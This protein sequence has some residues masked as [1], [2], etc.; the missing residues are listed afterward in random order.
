MENDN[1]NT[2]DSFIAE[3]TRAQELTTSL[4]SFESRKNEAYADAAL[5]SQDLSFPKL[6]TDGSLPD[7]TARPS[8]QQRSLSTDMVR[9]Y[10]E[11]ESSFADSDYDMIASDDEATTASI[12][13]GGQRTPEYSG[14]DA[15]NEEEEHQQ[16]ELPQNDQAKI[17][18]VSG[19]FVDLGEYDTPTARNNVPYDAENMDNSVLSDDLETPRQS[20][21][22]DTFD[23]LSEAHSTARQHRSATSSRVKVADRPF[24]ILFVSE[25]NVSDSQ[26]MSICSK[27]GACLEPSTSSTTRFNVV[28]LPSSPMDASWTDAELLKDDGVVLDIQHCVNATP[29]NTKAGS[30]SVMLALKDPQ[31]FRLVEGGKVTDPQ[32]PDMARDLPDLVVLFEVESSDKDHWAEHIFKAFSTTSVPYLALHSYE[33]ET[34]MPNGEPRTVTMQTQSFH[35]MS[36]KSFVP[37][38]RHLLQ[39]QQQEAGH[40]KST[41][42]ADTARYLKRLAVPLVVP[43]ILFFIMTSALQ[44]LFMPSTVSPQVELA[45][46]RDAVTSALVRLTNA[47]HVGKTFEI[48]KL[49]PDSSVDM[50]VDGRGL[51]RTKFHTQWAQP[52]HVLLSMPKFAGSRKHRDPSSITVFKNTQDVAFNS[53]KLTDGVVHLALDVKQCYGQ[54]MV[55]VTDDKASFNA[56]VTPNFGYWNRKTST[57]LSKVVS[58]DDALFKRFR[59]TLGVAWVE[60]INAGVKATQNVTALM[61]EHMRKDIQVVGT[62]ALQAFGHA[63]RFGNSTAAFIRKDLELAK[64]DLVHSGQI[65]Q[66]AFKSTTQSVKA[67]VPS[68][69][70][71]NAPF[72]KSRK[73]ALRLKDKLGRRRNSSQALSTRT[74]LAAY[75]RAPLEAL[76]R[77]VPAIRK[78]LSKAGDFTRCML[79]RDF[80][81]CRKAQTEVPKS[82]SP[83]YGNS[84]KPAKDLKAHKRLEELK[85]KARDAREK[86]RA[87]ARKVSDEAEKARKGAKEAKANAAKRG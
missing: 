41:T 46:R 18:D 1:T 76:G 19:S 87:A 70:A 80:A 60:N 78:E 25:R 81:A 48:K 77:P 10:A 26:K 30:L 82:L 72:A 13:S 5:S 45:M 51:E 44:S 15:G 4:E 40:E 33:D 28:R 83:V 43:L 14:S 16:D 8:S 22:S 50:S 3:Q 52:N 75:I 11:S 21:A 31:S 79:A 67:L 66:R 23:S 42:L 6:N 53:T 58:R 86:K 71:L 38:I 59:R 2:N 47:T 49:L 61:A 39:S 29:Y 34:S 32:A 74:D 65:A 27:I 12:A 62:T 73:N 37:Y 20:T 17:E 68:R 36:N 35:E 63:A 55:L 85:F 84:I 24:R 69:H 57:E 64:K 54:L 7:L 9:Q 56:T